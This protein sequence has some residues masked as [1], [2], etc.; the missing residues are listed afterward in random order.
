MG[1]AFLRSARLWLV[2]C[3]D[4]RAWGAAW[5]AGASPAH[6]TELQWVCAVG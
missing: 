2:S 6:I 1:A 3:W 5:V 4:V